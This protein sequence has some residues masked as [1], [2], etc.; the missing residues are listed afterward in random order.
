MK[1]HWVSWK[2][3]VKAQ[4]RQEVKLR[5]HIIEHYMSCLGICMWFFF[6]Y[7]HDEDG[8][9]RKKNHEGRRTWYKKIFSERCTLCSVKFSISL[10]M[11]IKS[12]T[13][14]FWYLLHSLHVSFIISI[15][16]YSTFINDLKSWTCKN[17]LN[18]KI[19]KY[20]AKFFRIDTRRSWSVTTLL[21]ELLTLVSTFENVKRHMKICNDLNLKMINIA[22]L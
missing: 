2:G 9:K 8:M 1:S 16:K 18:I 22:L 12:L 6:C 19:L 5:T 3:I 15:E 20:L 17:H 14:A 11:K 7:H 21:L 4:K 10:I 13:N